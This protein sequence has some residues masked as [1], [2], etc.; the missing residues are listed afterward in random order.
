MAMLNY[1]QIPVRSLWWNVWGPIHFGQIFSRW[2]HDDYHDIGVRSFPDPWSF[3]KAELSKQ[4]DT[5]E[6]KRFFFGFSSVK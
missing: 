2:K 3:E 4:Q 1:Q 5:G 6:S